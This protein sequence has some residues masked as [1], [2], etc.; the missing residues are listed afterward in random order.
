MAICNQDRSQNLLPLISCYTLKATTWHLYLCSSVV[1][2]WSCA[3]DSWDPPPLNNL[4]FVK[5]L[6]HACFPQT[7]RLFTDH[8]NPKIPHELQL[9]VCE[10]VKETKNEFAAFPLSL[11]SSLILLSVTIFSV[12]LSHN[13]FLQNLFSM[14]YQ[15]GAL[16]H[17]S[18]PCWLWS[19][20]QH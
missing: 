10:W 3:A 4:S 17:Y 9:A 15:S 19:K 8:N 11:F 2:K 7:C 5:L 6:L 14:F 16:S 12:A 20:S 13:F 18:F 1:C